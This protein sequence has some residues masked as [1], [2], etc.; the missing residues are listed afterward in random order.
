[1]STCGN[2]DCAD[3]SQ[4]VKKGNGYTIEIIETEKSLY[5]NTVSEVP[6]AEHDGK[7]N[8]HKCS[9]FR[10]CTC[11]HARPLE[12]HSQCSRRSCKLTRETHHHKSTNLSSF[13]LS[14]L[15]P[16]DDSSPT[17]NEL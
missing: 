13:S 14:S 1:M 17:L 8:P 11:H 15:N 3:K 7:C 2:C 16:F 10:T 12:P 6:A 9:C 5:E 4:C